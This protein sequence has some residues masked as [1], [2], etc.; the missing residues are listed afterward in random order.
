MKVTDNQIDKYLNEFAPASLEEV[1]KIKS[2][3]RSN[4]KYVFSIRKLPEIL[5]E[6]TA[7]Y[8]LLYVNEIAAHPHTTVYYDTPEYAMYNAH[9]NG[10]LSRCKLRHK[11]YDESDSGYL[12]LKYKNNKREKRKNKIKF[13]LAAQNLVEADE[14]LKKNSPFTAADLSPQIVIKY[15]RLTFLNIENGE[16]IT[17]D[18]ELNVAAYDNQ[19]KIINLEHL[20]VLEIKR[21]NNKKQSFISDLLITHKI[22]L[23]GMSKY[24]IGLAAVNKRLKNNR[25]KEKM[26]IL[27]KF[28]F[29]TV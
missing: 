7:H 13:C 9:Q 1:K 17:C 23:K 16:R 28:K 6:M 4:S 8:K 26:R 29:Q 2:F 10:K 5:V 18:Y 12:E 11:N 27:D 21:A 25:F 22:Q 19:E 15:T 24:C 3:K 20:C 14:F